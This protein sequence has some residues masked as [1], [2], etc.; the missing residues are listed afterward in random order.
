L[1]AYG[2]ADATHPQVPSS[3]ATFKSR[4]VLP[5]WYQFIQIVLEKK[6]LNGRSNSNSSNSSSGICQFTERFQ[7]TTE[8]VRNLERNYRCHAHGI[9]WNYRSCMRHFMTTV[10]SRHEATIRL[11]GRRRI[12]AT[13]LS[14]ISLR[15]AVAE[16]LTRCDCGVTGPRFESHRRRLCSSRQPLRYTALGT[17]CA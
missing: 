11:S 2:L 12:Q 4:L 14:V 5:F 15:V 9:S 6:P 3:L 16:W 17:G 7:E 8:I 1:F 13:T 10:L